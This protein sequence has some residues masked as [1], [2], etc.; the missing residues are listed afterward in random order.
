MGIAVDSTSPQ[1]AYVIPRVISPQTG[2]AVP[3]EEVFAEVEGRACG[4]IEIVGDRGAGKTTAL[5]FLETLLP[6]AGGFVL[7]DEP[8]PTRLA[9]A[10]ANSI[11]IYSS[12]EPRAAE[13]IQSFPLAPWGDDELME[14]L[15]AAHPEQCRSVMSRLRRAPDHHLLGGNPELWSIV[16]ER[17]AADEA[18]AEPAMALEAELQSRM[19]ANFLRRE[20]VGTWLRVLVRTSALE[21]VFQRLAKLAAEPGLIRLLRHRALQI[22]LAAVDFAHRLEQGRAKPWLAGRLPRALV[23]RTAGKLSPAALAKLRQITQED[24]DDLHA[25]AASLLHAARCGWRPEKLPLCLDGA[26]LAGADWPGIDLSEAPLMAADLS[27]SNLTDAKLVRAKAERANF[28][29]AVLRRADVQEIQALVANFAGADLSEA[30]G[31]KG[32]FQAACLSGAILTRA[33]LREA[34]FAM[35]DLAGA[36]LQS[37]D[38]TYAVLQPTIIRGADF[39]SANLTGAWLS[40]LVLREATF[41][42]ARFTGATLSGCDMEGMELPDANFERAS[43]VDAMLTGSR[44]RRGCFRAADVRRAALADIDWEQADL[45]DADLRGCVF[46]MGSSRSGLVGS[47]I[48]SEGSR[49]GF[50]TDEY[51]Q[52]YFRPPEEI[53]KANLRGA[54]LRGARIEGTDFYLVDLRGARCDPHQRDHFR[55][56][57]AILVGQRGG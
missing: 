14:Y 3:I 27:D 32:W 6:P 34:N 29:G 13:T 56:C 47:P 53:R 33:G 54:D 17:M 25:T 42:G 19:P 15:L 10:A 18:I 21:P 2:D 1:N 20:A 12:R 7:L 16:L 48:A 22:L 55:R 31:Q 45:R 44:I 40:G 51:D 24:R 9:Q 49:T 52:Q 38:L 43:L 4:A 5:A 8:D 50:Y 41:L 26:H 30:N 37:A 57:G 39:S 46:H 11:A 23:E 28:S 35:A 36:C